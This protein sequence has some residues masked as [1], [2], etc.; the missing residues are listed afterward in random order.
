MI[1]KMAVVLLVVAALIGATLYW[2]AGNMDRMVKHAIESYGSEMTQAK[3]SLGAVKISPS[4]GKG[5]ISNL[6][7]GNPTGFKTP[8]VLQVAQLEVEIDLA[9]LTQD[10]VHIRRIAILAPDVIYEKGASQ[11][12]LDAISSHIA[13]ASSTR[14]GDGVQKTGKK[15]IVD[16]LTMQ[17]AQAQASAAFMNG[18][19]VA[20]ALPDLTLKDIGRAKGGVTAGELG[21]AITTALTARLSPAANFDRLLKSGSGML[22]QVESSVKKLFK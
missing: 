21:Q 9:S 11:T 8:H 12:N 19:T 7:V 13:N 18:K 4:S 14:Q 3:V 10:V 17:N 2:L 22:D 16:L 5:L 6:T 15:L 20:I 1:K